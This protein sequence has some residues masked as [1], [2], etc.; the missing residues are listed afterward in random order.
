MSQRK[1]LLKSI[2]KLETKVKSAK[3]NEIKHRYYFAQLIGRN[4][5]LLAAVLVP[6]FLSGWQSGK[7]A[8]G[9]GRHRLKQFGKYGFAT[10]FKLIRNYNKLI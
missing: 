1:E 9:Q 7:V 10:F 2:A 5:Y 3:K 6:A 4:P 8:R